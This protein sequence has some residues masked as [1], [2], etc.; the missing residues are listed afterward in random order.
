MLEGDGGI[1]TEG[2]EGGGE[3]AWEVESAGIL[4]AGGLLGGGSGEDAGGGALVGTAAGLLG[5]G[6]LGGG[7]VLLGGGAGA[8]DV[9]VGSM[10]ACAASD[11]TVVPAA[12][13]VAADVIEPRVD[14][15]PSGSG[16]PNG[17]HARSGL[18]ELPT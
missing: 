12:I 6:G 7:G 11:R 10:T 4:W 8:V 1:T 15:A 5:C 3:S 2:G 18:I 9:I 17:S 16:P 13:W 14:V